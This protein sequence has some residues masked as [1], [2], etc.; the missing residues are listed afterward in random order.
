MNVKNI[1]SADDEVF[2]DT[3]MTDDISEE[4][5]DLEVDVDEETIEE[6]IFRVVDKSKISQRVLKFWEV[7]IDEGNLGKYLQAN[8]PD[9]EVRQFS[10]PQW[11][12]EMN[13]AQRDFRKLV[14][15]EKPHHVM[16]APECRLWSP[17][18]N[19]NYRTPERRALL[20][21][22]RNLEESTHLKFY[23]DIHSDS[24]KIYY[25]CTRDSPLMR[26]HGKPRLWRR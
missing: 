4:E 2:L 16:V 1:N 24:K 17:M 22:M 11:N 21:D 7:Y 18:Q 25:D 14:A 3:I 20:A 10:L 5:M 9:V 26:F 8:Y 19:L 23:D 12:F 15:E 13:E 6:V